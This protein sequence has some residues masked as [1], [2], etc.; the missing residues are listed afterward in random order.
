MG[1]PESLRHL[2]S[3]QKIHHW[4]RT[5]ILER[6]C[7]LH[8]Q[9]A[10]PQT[11]MLEPTSFCQRLYH[12]FRWTFIKEFKQDHIGISKIHSILKRYAS[13]EPVNYPRLEY[14]LLSSKYAIPIDQ[15]SIELSNQNN[16]RFFMGMVLIPNSGLLSKPIAF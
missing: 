8:L 7:N 14:P 2:L 13:H 11:Q 1:Q 15:T 5:Y 12:C 6:L 9:H 3:K 4:S 16:G 10:I